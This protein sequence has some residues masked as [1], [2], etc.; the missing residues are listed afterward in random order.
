MLD[1]RMIPNPTL[2]RA[3]IDARLRALGHLPASIQPRTHASYRQQ[4]WRR[5][6]GSSVLLCEVHPLGERLV[7]LGGDALDELM[8]ALEVIPRAT[9]LQEA[10]HAPGPREALPWLR[11]LCLLEY[12]AASPELR[13]QLT[14]LLGSDDLFVRSAAAAVILHLA[15]GQSVWALEILVQAETEPTQREWFTRTLEAERDLQD[16]STAKKTARAGKRS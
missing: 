5:A 16:G 2:P 11:R 12:D 14:P 15:P 4:T 13:E 10:V 3:E 9:L 8:R 7:A 6:D 1:Q